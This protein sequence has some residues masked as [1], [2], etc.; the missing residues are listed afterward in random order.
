[1]SLQSFQEGF[2]CLWECLQNGLNTLS[3]ISLTEYNNH[4]P[5]PFN[6]K[7][8]KRRGFYALQGSEYKWL[9]ISCPVNKM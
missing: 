1:M 7:V 4:S 6:P 3:F 9:S 8:V 5:M 2:Y